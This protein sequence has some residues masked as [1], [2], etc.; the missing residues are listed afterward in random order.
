MSRILLKAKH[1][2]QVETIILVS[3][4]KSFVFYYVSFTFLNCFVK[5]KLYSIYV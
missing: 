5:K 4:I 2:G 1:N 3:K